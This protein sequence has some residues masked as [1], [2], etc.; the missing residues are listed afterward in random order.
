[1][2]V[3]NPDKALSEALNI[4]DKRYSIHKLYY[5]GSGFHAVP[6]EVL[7][8]ERVVHLSLEEVEY[9]KK[10]G[11]GVKVKGDYRKAPFKSGYFDATLVWGIPPETALEAIDEFL[12]V[13]KEDGL[14][15]V[16]SS[17]ICY[18]PSSF[19]FIQ[20]NLST[21]IERVTI[22]GLNPEIS[23]YKNKAKV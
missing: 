13:T 21:L 23:V 8:I 6:K 12:R 16:G 18:M 22:K 3:L 11:S 17:R 10:L 20:Y 1:M 19:D 15:I 9:F 2:F 7:G 14:L 5:P 4:L